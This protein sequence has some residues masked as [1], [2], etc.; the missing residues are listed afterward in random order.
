MEFDAD[1]FNVASGSVAA[2]SDDAMGMVIKLNVDGTEANDI[3]LGYTD[4]GGFPITGIGTAI[5]YTP[6]ADGLIF[7]R[8]AA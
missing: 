7:T 4:A 1:E 3:A 6:S 8:A 2:G 5:N